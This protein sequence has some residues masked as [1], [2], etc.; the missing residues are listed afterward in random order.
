MRYLVVLLLFLSAPTLFA[1]DFADVDKS[2]LD[3][4]YYPTRAAF[5]AFAE[6]DSAAMAMEPKIRVIYSRPFKKGRKVWITS[7]V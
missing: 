5:R 2:P 1:Q 3:A 6:T 4:V 7:G